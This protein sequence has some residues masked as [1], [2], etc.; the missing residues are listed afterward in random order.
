MTYQQILKFY[1]EVSK[2][3]LKQRIKIKR[4]FICIAIKAFWRLVDL[5]I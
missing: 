2:V 5:A 1:L 3:D 4:R